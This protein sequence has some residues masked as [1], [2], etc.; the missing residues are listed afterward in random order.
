MKKR[1]PNKKRVWYEREKFKGFLLEAWK[2]QL[3]TLIKDLKDLIQKNT[4]AG[5]LS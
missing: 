4:D 2:L 1:K 3:S 5:N